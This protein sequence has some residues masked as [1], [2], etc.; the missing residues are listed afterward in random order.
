MKKSNDTETQKFIDS[1]AV[2]D[3]AKYQILEKLRE[4]VFEHYPEVM[5]RMMYGGIM[6]SLNEDVG[7]IF[8]YKQHISFEFGNG[9]KFDDPEKIL[10][11]KGKY[12]RHVKLGS[13]DDVEMKRV[14]FFVGQIKDFGS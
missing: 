3:P 7:G 11:G 6:Y 12:R 9:Y 8:V 14:G 2:L 5:E 4:I 1:I 13:L 10:E